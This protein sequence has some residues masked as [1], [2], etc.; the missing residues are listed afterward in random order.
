METGALKLKPQFPFPFL[1][2]I[3][4]DFSEMSAMFDS[5][6]HEMIC[7]ALLLL[8][9]PRGWSLGPMLLFLPE[10]VRLFGSLSSL[11]QGP[12]DPLHV[13]SLRPLH[14]KL[15]WCG[16]Y[17][18]HW[19]LATGAGNLSVGLSFHICKIFSWLTKCCSAFSI[20]EQRYPAEC[21]MEMKMFI[22]LCGPV[23]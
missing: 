12:H 8:R 9:L 21:S 5:S 10:S 17:S 22:Y 14:F 16:G 20:I 15:H 7:F 18:R 4:L 13:T 1:L 11:S 6:V 3:F 2:Y 23:Q 19:L